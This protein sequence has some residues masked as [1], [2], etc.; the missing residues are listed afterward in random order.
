MDA[1]H[2]T[3]NPQAESTTK[4]PRKLT[5]ARERVRVLSVRSNLMTGRWRDTGAPCSPC[6]S[7]HG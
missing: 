3:K 6:T 5:F 4:E 7:E 2:D 1:K